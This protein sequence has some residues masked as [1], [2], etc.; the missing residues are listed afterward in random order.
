MVYVKIAERVQ[1]FNLQ[2]TCI[3]EQE[4]LTYQNSHRWKKCLF[5]LFMHLSNCG[6]FVVVKQNI[7]ATHAIFHAKVPLLPEEYDIIIMRRTGVEPVTDEVIYQ[8]FRVR[9][10]AI[11]LWLE[12]LVQ[13]HPTFRSRQVAVDY[14]QLDQLPVDG[15]VHDQLRTMENEQMEDAFL[16]TGPLEASHDTEAQQP[17]PLFSAGFV[18]NLQDRHTEEDHL[19]QAAMQGDEPVILT[20]PSMHGTPINEHS[21]HHIAIDAF[22]TLFP[23]G[24]ADI[25]AERDEKVEMKD[26]ASHLMKLKGGRFARHPRFQYWVLNTMMRQTAQKA[27]NWYLH[28]HKED[29]DLTVEEIREMIEAGNVA[30]L[31]QRVANAGVK[32]AG[33]KPF[34]QSAQKDL[35]AQI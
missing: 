8:D 18:P 17:E 6:K 12:Y 9:R 3:L 2:T 21:G 15:L 20:M 11:Q 34:W 31:A 22:P 23:T 1:N 29:K 28:T 14:T 13:N 33:S 32:L 30:G 26:W 19:C 25:V 7:L 4:L 10:N 24:E 5:L 35:I 16:N 27:S